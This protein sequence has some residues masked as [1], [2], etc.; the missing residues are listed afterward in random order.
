MRGIAYELLDGYGDSTHEWTE[1]NPLAFHLRRRLSIEEQSRIGDA[2][3]CRGSDEGKIRLEKMR[4]VLPPDAI[5]FAEEELTGA[6]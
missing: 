6:L 3:D 1:N 5:A 4:A 2:V